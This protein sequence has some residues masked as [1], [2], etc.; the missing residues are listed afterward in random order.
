MIA[1]GSV[2][3]LQLSANELTNLN[4][5][6][7]NREH[8]KQFEVEQ[9]DERIKSIFISE[10]NKTIHDK[11]IRYDNNSSCKHGDDKPDGSPSPSS[12]TTENESREQFQRCLTAGRHPTI[13]SVSGS[14]RAI[15][16]AIA[17]ATISVPA[18]SNHHIN[19]YIN[20]IAHQ[21]EVAEQSDRGQQ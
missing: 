17:A 11:I 6:K 21:S 14:S 4:R 20:D 19:T 16:V 18:W 1:Y 9:S 8:S 12:A 10:L 5:I 15:N 7:K 3:H 2:K 13:A